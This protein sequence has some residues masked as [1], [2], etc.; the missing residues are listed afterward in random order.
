MQPQKP[1]EIDP[2]YPT[3]VAYVLSR[4]R[5]YVSTLQIQFEIGYPRAKELID[6]MEEEC[7]ISPLKRKRRKILITTNEWVN[8]SSAR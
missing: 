4:R 6:R 5:A 7:V 3:A 2:L 1:A 8:R